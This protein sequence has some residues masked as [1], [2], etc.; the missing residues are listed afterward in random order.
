MK[1]RFMLTLD[2]W[3]GYDDH[4][5]TRNVEI[6]PDGVQVAYGPRVPLLLFGGPVRPGIDSRWYAHASL[7]K[8][9]I[10]SWDLAGSAPWHR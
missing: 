1:Q 4:V 8:T 6:T 10:Q 5:A 9:V 3:G 2:D 7:P